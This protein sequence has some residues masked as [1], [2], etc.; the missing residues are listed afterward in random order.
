MEFLKLTGVLVVIL[1]FAF[2]MD[3]MFIVLVATITTAFASGIGFIELLGMFGRLFVANRG[4][5]IFI[6]L[7]LVTGTLERNGLC[8]AA[9]SLVNKIKN[10]TPGKILGIYAVIRGFFGAFNVGLGG[11]PGFI[12]PVLIPM[13]E[14]AIKAEGYEPD[15]HHMEE[16][17]GMAAGVEN[18]TWFFTEVLVIGGPAGLVVQSVLKEAGYTVSLIELAKSEIPVAIF[19]VII[20]IIYYNYRDKKLTEKYY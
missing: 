10:A 6:I 12:R 16:I 8:E 3:A 14:E 17:K 11:V 15:M 9:E 2:K 7:M 4:I 20:T 5:C 18:L 1:G 19:A 13:T